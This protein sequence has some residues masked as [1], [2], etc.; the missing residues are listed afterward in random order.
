MHPE[1][2]VMRFRYIFTFFLCAW[3]GFPPANVQAEESKSKP[4]PEAKGEEPRSISM[5]ERRLRRQLQYHKRQGALQHVSRFMHRTAP[6][7]RFTLGEIKQQYEAKGA[8]L[9]KVA[10]SSM[11]R[12][13]AVIQAKARALAEVKAIALVLQARIEAEERA[14]A[15]ALRQMK[16]QNPNYAE[17]A[18]RLAADATVNRGGEIVTQ[19]EDLPILSKTIDMDYLDTLKRNPTLVP[20]KIERLPIMPT[21][22]TKT[23]ETLEQPS[24]VPSFIL[25]PYSQENLQDLAQRQ[26]MTEY[27][28]QQALKRVKEAQRRA[29]ITQAASSTTDKRRKLKELLVLY[30]QDKISP[31]EYYE[32]R[33]LIMGTEPAEQ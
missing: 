29:E 19:T 33:G 4:L 8:A 20:G 23:Q 10:R 14:M 21:K 15:S 24:S 30:A 3:V 7:R 31:K 1:E 32:R 12:H 18:L 25:Q 16:E 28:K 9:A 13:Q 17:E 6:Y 11:L 22:S 26:A 2:G 27:E 5:R